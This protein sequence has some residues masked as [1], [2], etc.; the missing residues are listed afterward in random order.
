MPVMN[1]YEHLETAPEYL[2]PIVRLINWA[3]NETGLRTY[4]LFLDITGLSEELGLPPLAETGELRRGY[5]ECGLL[6]AALK[7]WSKRPIDVHYF[8][9]EYER[10]ALECA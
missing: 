9:E 4:W 3:D 2:A 1:E 8:I 10:L 7:L 6:S 5:L